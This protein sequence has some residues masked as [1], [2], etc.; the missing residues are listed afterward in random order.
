MNKHKEFIDYVLSFYGPEGLYPMGVTRDDVAVATGM[1]II[2]CRALDIEF[3]GDTF[4]RESV[5]DI[6]ID[7]FGYGWGG[8]VNNER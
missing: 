8:G 5:R 6:L 2:L 4:D 3:G 7:D 1:R